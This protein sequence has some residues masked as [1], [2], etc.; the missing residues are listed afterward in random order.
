MLLDDTNDDDANDDAISS[1]D[2]TV[3]DV[4]AKIAFSKTKLIKASL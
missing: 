3:V 1:C 4:G 2:C